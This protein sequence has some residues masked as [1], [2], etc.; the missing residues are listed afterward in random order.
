MKQGGA[1][2]RQGSPFN[3]PGLRLQPTIS[4]VRGSVHL[5]V[6]GP[7]VVQW[8]PWACVPRALALLHVWPMPGVG[9]MP[10]ARAGFI[11]AGAPQ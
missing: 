10:S 7:F 9:P 1:A 6:V 8:L 11:C 4:V 5:F 2:P 3:P